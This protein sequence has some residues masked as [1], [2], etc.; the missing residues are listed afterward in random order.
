[1]IPFY[2][3]KFS[4]GFTLIELIVVVF[5]VSIISLVSYPHM[6]NVYSSYKLYDET[7]G[8]FTDFLWAQSYAVK[9][10]CPVTLKFDENESKYEIFE[11]HNEDN[12]RDSDEKTLYE[13]HVKS[14]EMYEVRFGSGKATRFD[15][16]GNISLL[17]HIY[18]KK[19]NHYR[20]VVVRSLAGNIAIKKSCDGEN[21]N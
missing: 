10:N 14:S 13:N 7:S 3:N 8:I 2:K 17:G 6:S 21:W 1:M 9:H 12:K 11:D 15:A 18:L 20:A 19:D 5:I 4:F 16:N